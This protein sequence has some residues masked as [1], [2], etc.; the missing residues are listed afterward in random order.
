MNKRKYSSPEIDIVSLKTFDVLAASTYTPQPEIP[1][2]AGDE[3]ID[4]DL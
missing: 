3:G 4:G 1:T 2:R